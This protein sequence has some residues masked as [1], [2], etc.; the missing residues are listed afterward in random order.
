MIETYV[1]PSPRDTLEF[2]DEKHEEL[3]SRSCVT[4]RLRPLQPGRTTLNVKYER[5]TATVNISAFPPLKW[6]LPGKSEMDGLHTAVV[7]LFSTATVQLVGGP[8]PMGHNLGS[9]AVDTILVA[10]D[11]SVAYHESDISINKTRDEFTHLIDENGVPNGRL[12]SFHCKKL[13]EQTITIIVANSQSALIT[14][15]MLDVEPVERRVHLN[16][17]CANPKSS[18]IIMHPSATIE[19]TAKGPEE[20]TY[21]ARTRAPVSIYLRL[22]DEQDRPFLNFSTIDTSW[23]TDDGNKGNLKLLFRRCAQNDTL[24]KNVD[25]YGNVDMNIKK[26]CEMFG[27]SGKFGE[28]P[29]IFRDLIVVGG[30]GEDEKKYTQHAM[31]QRKYLF[32]KRI[33]KIF[34]FLFFIFSY[35]YIL[36]SL[37]SLLMRPS[38]FFYRCSQG[39]CTSY[40]KYFYL[41]RQTWLWCYE[42]G[43]TKER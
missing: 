11:E 32:G 8:Q 18:Q 19:G 22:L 28:Y 27:A 1:G 13:D 39:T 12:Y 29:G 16:F 41:S 43:Y 23:F 7:S 36:L 31:L 21:F 35:S 4:L 33:F 14:E 20:P 38:F 9:H 10:S 30:Y 2:V 3:Y 26:D 25:E 37:L 6:V 5:H 40:S 15:D 17:V 34:T 42:N 24:L